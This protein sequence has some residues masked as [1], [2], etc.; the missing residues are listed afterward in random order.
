MTEFEH[1]FGS[2]GY[3]QIGNGESVARD[4]D[5]QNLT[6]ID[7]IIE[8]L[9]SPR[10]TP[11]LGRNS[12]TIF[13]VRG[14]EEYSTAARFGAHRLKHSQT[15]EFI[16][17]ANDFNTVHQARKSIKQETA[18][19]LFLKSVADKSETINSAEEYD[20]LTKQLFNKRTIF[21]LRDSSHFNI[22]APPYGASH[23]EA[24]G[25][26]V[27]EVFKGGDRL[28]GEGLLDDDEM[29]V[30]LKEQL[31]IIMK[32]QDLKTEESLIIWSALR[33][34]SEG[35]KEED[36]GSQKKWAELEEAVRNDLDYSDNQLT[37]EVTRGIINSINYDRIAILEKNL[38]K[39]CRTLGKN[40]TRVAGVDLTQTIIRS[41]DTEEAALADALIRKRITQVSK[42]P[43]KDDLYTFPLDELVSLANIL[44]NVGNLEVTKYLR[45]NTPTNFPPAVQRVNQAVLKNQPEGTKKE[46]LLL[47]ADCAATMMEQSLVLEAEEDDG[48]VSI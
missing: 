14:L 15:L 31:T 11:S 27:Q 26:C 9:P 43:G 48:T 23:G 33:A 40:D 28:V 6:S 16:E 13:E 8:S 24:L 46:S 17:S 36:S 29:F 21:A 30:A 42:E 19:K 22:L 10:I 35:K 18:G 34:H 4:V 38:P 3:E 7:V 32:T 41:A 25:A 37:N 20:E 44:T 39:I 45:Q 5:G 47:A 12:P 2:G 1:F